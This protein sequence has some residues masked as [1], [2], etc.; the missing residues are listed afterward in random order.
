MIDKRALRLG[1]CLTLSLCRVPSPSVFTVCS[2]H[3]SLP[4]LSTTSL[5]SVFGVCRRQTIAKL[6][7][8]APSPATHL[9]SSFLTMLATKPSLA[10]PSTR[11][12]CNS[13]QHC[14]GIALNRITRVSPGHTKLT[15][16]VCGARDERKK[17]GTRPATL[18][19]SLRFSNLSQKTLSTCYTMYKQCTTSLQPHDARHKA[20]KLDTGRSRK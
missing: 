11:D 8:D 12:I 13:Q 16:K 9:I 4:H 7:V 3:I 18:L 5:Y 20:I 6:R 14:G 19:S 2:F 1:V 17:S 10:S 15:E